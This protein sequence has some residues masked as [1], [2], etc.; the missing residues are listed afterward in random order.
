LNEADAAK[1][2]G[3]LEVEVKGLA[4]DSRKVDKGFVF[5]AVKGTHVDGHNYISKAIDQGAVA[6]VCEHLPLQSF[7]NTLFIKVADSA[8]A[9]GEMASMFYGEPSRKLKLVGITGTNGKT[10]TVSLLHALTLNLGHKAGLISTISYKINT[11]EFPSSHTTPD[12]L[13]LNLLLQQM[14]EAGC[15]YCFMEVSSHAIDQQRI[16]GLDFDGAIFSNITHDHLDYHKTFGTYIKAKK[17]YFDN[18]KPDAFALTNIDDKNGMVMLQNTRA[19]KKTYSL[20]TLADFKTKIIESHFDGALM[21]IDGHEVWTHFVGRFNAYN[22]LAVYGTALL[23]GFG[24]FR[25]H[26]ICFGCLCHCRLCPYPRCF[27]KCSFNHRGDA[28]KK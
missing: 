19:N 20:R 10:T 14:V 25:N 9:L 24:T 8:R 5:F 28:H 27:R 11:N 13:Q 18:L 4:F 3:N 23:L 22:L 21:N 7:G 15:E 6:I 1:L 2:E 26:P 12:Q 17:Q 16:A